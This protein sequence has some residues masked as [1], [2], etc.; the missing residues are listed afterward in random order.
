MRLFRPVGLYE[1]AL[2]WDSGMRQFPPRLSHQPIFYP[3]TS[4][5]Y[6]IQIA[7]DWNTRDESSG[8]AGYVTE[9]VIPDSY[10]EKFE[11]HAVGSLSRVEYW[12]PAK[13]LTGF[14]A[15]IQGLISVQE[16]F[17]GKDFLAA[18]GASLLD[19]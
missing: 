17:F 15:S 18:C 11:P 14:N 8:F 6:A 5:E 16:A 3:V 12:I 9:F 1:L 4:T 10:I 13:E 2:I 7:K 19:S